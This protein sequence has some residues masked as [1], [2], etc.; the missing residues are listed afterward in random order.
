[1][2]YFTSGYELWVHF[3]LIAI[4]GGCD[5]SEDAKADIIRWLFYTCKQENQ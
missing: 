4:S 3:A 1:M 5:S 2:G